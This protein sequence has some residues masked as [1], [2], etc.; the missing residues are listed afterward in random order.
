MSV[1]KGLPSTAA[2]PDLDW[3]QISE[4]VRML[5]LAVAQISMAMHE[6]DDSVGA[7]TTSFTDMVSTVD[8][9]ACIA[10]DK[11]ADTDAAGEIFFQCT[12]VQS[13]MQQSIVAF[14][15]YDRLPQRLDHVKQALEQLGSLVSDSARLYNPREWSN[16][17]EHIR[18]RYT[19]REEQEMFEALLGGERVSNRLSRW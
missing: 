8:E 2:S 16:L 14:Q 12:R 3:S 15:F 1:V 19:M 5:N 4:T 7:L 9:I 10:N 18:D 13:G 6:G 11:I 17:Q